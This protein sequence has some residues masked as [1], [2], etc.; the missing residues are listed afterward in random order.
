M[1]LK[2]KQ[3]KKAELKNGVAYENKYA[4]TNNAANRGMVTCMQ[5]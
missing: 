4:S 2:A 5:K 1:E 3:L